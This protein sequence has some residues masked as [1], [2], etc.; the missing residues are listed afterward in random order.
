MQRFAVTQ[1]GRGQN[2]IET[3]ES[4]EASRSPVANVMH[5]VSKSGVTANGNGPSSLNSAQCCDSCSLDIHVR[6][7]G[8]VLSLCR[9]AAAAQLAQTELPLRVIRSQPAIVKTGMNR[10][11]GMLGTA[12][13][14]P[15]RKCTIG[16]RS[17]RSQRMDSPYASQILQSL[18]NPKTQQSQY[19][20]DRKRGQEP[21]AKW[22]KGCF[23]LLVPDPFS[24]SMVCLQSAS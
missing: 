15:R 12:D 14:T 22:P 19:V 16:C 23:A 7:I 9:T 13:S 6:D 8:Q 1:R 11:C 10:A 21:I 4:T 17:E 20:V 2:L 3:N 24:N 5:I 18:R